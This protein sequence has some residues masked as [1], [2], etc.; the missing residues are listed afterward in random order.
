MLESRRLLIKWIAGSPDRA[1]IL[2]SID[3]SSNPTETL[4]IAVMHTISQLFK[5]L[6]HA[7]TA[8]QLFGLEIDPATAE[9][10]HTEAQ[11]LSEIYLKLREERASKKVAN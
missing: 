4:E 10:Y 5:D 1:K 8:Q 11:T 9:S 2:E 6:I 7:H 3:A